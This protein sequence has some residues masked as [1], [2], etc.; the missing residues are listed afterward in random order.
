MQQSVAICFP[1]AQR[2]G[3]LFHFAQ[4]IWKKVQGL[5][6]RILYKK[7]EFRC[8]ANPMIALAFAVSLFKSVQAATQVAAGG[9]PVRK[10]RKY[11]NHERRLVTIKKYK[12]G[13][14]TLNELACSH[15]VSF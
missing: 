10:R 9:L 11:R 5:G 13:N 15:W 1:Q 14:Y 3:C 7:D 8:F 12:A 6:L 4:A 2:K